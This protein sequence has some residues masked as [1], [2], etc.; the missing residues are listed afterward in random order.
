MNFTLHTT[1]KA[2][3]DMLLKQKGKHI[4]IKPEQF[5]KGTR[6]IVWEEDT[7]KYYEHSI[8]EFME[9]LKIIE[10]GGDVFASRYYL[11]W[12]YKGT[13]IETRIKNLEELFND[14][15]RNGIINAVHCE[16][17]GERL[18]GSYRTKIAMYLG[19]PEVSA[20][21]HK[22]KWQDIDEEF[23]ERKIKARNLA[24]GRDYYYFKYGYKDWENIYN[25][26]EVYQ[27]NAS[28][29]ELIKPLVKGSVLDLGC[30][31]GYISIQLARNGHKV[32]GIDLE[33]IELAWLNK[34]IFEW[35]DKK[36]IDVDFHE[37]SILDTKRSADTILF[38]NVLYH[39]PKEKQA[40][41]IN[42]YKNKRLIFQ[43]NLRKEAEREKYYTSHPDDLIT[44][45]K[46]VG[47]DYKLIEWK[48]KPIIVCE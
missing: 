42:R 26:G 19:I 21:L 43:C 8:E 30:N 15:K 22:F 29:W 4:V 28:R 36:D 33:W 41:M 32:T 38:L 39:I 47:R 5:H 40:E 20:V 14:I 25:G 9:L 17:T 11:K 37:E 6:P 46:E 12:A 16:V 45:L 7:G 13:E 48:D 35:I 27:E 2:E 10:F 18:D 31:E 3:R 34:L 44:L 24:F 1:K 23:I